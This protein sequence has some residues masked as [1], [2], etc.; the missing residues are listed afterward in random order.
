MGSGTPSPSTR[1]TTGNSPA[2]SKVSTALA[3]P[4]SVGANRTSIEQMPPAPIDV[5][6]HESDTISNT[7]DDSRDALVTWIDPEVGLLNTTDSVL[8]PASITVGS[9]VTGAAKAVRSGTGAGSNCENVE[10]LLRRGTVGKRTVGNGAET[11]GNRGTIT[12]AGDVVAGTVVVGSLPVSGTVGDGATVVEGVVEV[13]E[14][15]V[16]TT[17]TFDDARS[18]AHATDA[19][20]DDAAGVDESARSDALA[21]TSQRPNCEIATAPV[22]CAA[23]SSSMP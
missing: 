15:V 19:A 11:V 14:V 3:G 17:S 10:V 2:S 7:P 23:E 1:A 8:R 6:L 16:S 9:K 20:W 4:T 12:V 13:V 18:I 5:S 22:G 21:N